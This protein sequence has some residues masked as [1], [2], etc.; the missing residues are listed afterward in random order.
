M[1]LVETLDKTPLLVRETDQFVACVSIHV[2]S[3]RCNVALKLVAAA[4]SVREDK[5]RCGAARV[6]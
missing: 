3:N 1:Q 6:A 5:L 4:N 2:F